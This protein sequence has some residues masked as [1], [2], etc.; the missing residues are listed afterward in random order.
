MSSGSAAYTSSNTVSTY[1]RP[2]SVRRCWMS[3]EPVWVFPYSTSDKPMLP[4]SSLSIAPDTEPADNVDSSSSVDKVAPPPPLLPPLL[5]P[6]VDDARDR[7]DP[8]APTPP[9]APLGT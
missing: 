2:F 4:G 1:A 7:V 3:L 5:L 8:S 6:E 9:A